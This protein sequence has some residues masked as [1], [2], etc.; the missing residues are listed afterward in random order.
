M[1]PKPVHRIPVWLGTFGDRALSVSGRLAD[2]WIPSLGYVPM[3]S[4]GSRCA[5]FSQPPRPPATVARQ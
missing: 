1:E 4:L 2:G 3:T 5:R